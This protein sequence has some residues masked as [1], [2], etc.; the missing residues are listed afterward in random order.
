MKFK[1]AVALIAQ[2]EA[3]EPNKFQAWTWF[4]RGLKDAERWQILKGS[5]D[6]DAMP[7]AKA[8]AEFEEHWRFEQAEAL[9]E[10]TRLDQE[11]GLYDEDPFF[12]LA[13]SETIGGIIYRTESTEFSRE[14]HPDSAEARHIKKKK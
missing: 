4:G 5:E 1:E 3:N 2:W 10:M 13:D 8:V 11:M 14:D 6:L 12:H 9:A 7:F